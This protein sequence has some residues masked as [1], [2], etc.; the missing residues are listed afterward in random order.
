MIQFNESDVCRL[1]RA[2]EYYKKDTGS[3]Y[4]WDV[5]DDLQTKLKAYGNE[6]TT[7]EDLSCP[8]E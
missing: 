2:C 8:S 1:I 4:M 6:V 7:T 5:Y 3:D